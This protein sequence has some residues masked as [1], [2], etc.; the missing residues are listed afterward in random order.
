MK[1]NSTNNKNKT[2]LKVNSLGK[3]LGST[4]KKNEMGYE[5]EEFAVCC[6]M[7]PTLEYINE[8]RMLDSG[9]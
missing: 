9:Q 1:Q 8:N 4:L 6:L 2:K 7:C 3:N 5:K